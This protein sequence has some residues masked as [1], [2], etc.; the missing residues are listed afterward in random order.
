MELNVPQIVICN[1]VFCPE[2]RVKLNLYNSLSTWHSISSIAALSEYLPTILL[3]YNSQISTLYGDKPT[4]YVIV[5]GSSFRFH[6]VLGHWGNVYPICMRIC[7]EK[8]LMAVKYYATPA[9]IYTAICIWT[10]SNT[11]IQRII[12][13][14]GCVQ[15]R[16]WS[17]LHGCYLSTVTSFALP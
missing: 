16:Q 4:S 7:L 17:P 12:N 9:S 1:P 10:L 2:Q 15:C 13:L 11:F 8:C 14:V 5:F 6:A 3:Q